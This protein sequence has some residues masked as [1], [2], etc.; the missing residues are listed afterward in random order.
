MVVLVDVGGDSAVKV[1]KIPVELIVFADK[2]DK[3]PVKEV[4]RFYLGVV[5]VVPIPVFVLGAVC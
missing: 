1:D 4:V 5:E 2:V 3:T